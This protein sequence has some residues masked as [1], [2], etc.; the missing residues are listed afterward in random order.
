MGWDI[1]GSIGGL[2]GDGSGS[3]TGGLLG[4]IWDEAGR[5]S[6]STTTNDYT[7]SPWDTEKAK[8]LN[9][10]R[11]ILFP[12]MTPDL[13]GASTS[14]SQGASDLATA[15]G[16]YSGAASGK[17]KGDISLF[18]SMSKSMGKNNNAMN[19]AMQLYGYQPQTQGSYS[20]E[21]DPSMMQ[22]IAALVSLGKSGYNAT[23]SFD[24]MGDSGTSGGSGY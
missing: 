23:K 22:K 17:G 21:S 15:K 13:A 10:L 20:K 2:L 5:N 14:K 24:N 9:M 11:S 18:D 19:M 3:V 1:G 4:P 12:S 16:I 7:P 8:T 6:V